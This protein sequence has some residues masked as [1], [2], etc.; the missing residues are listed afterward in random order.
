WLPV[1]GEQRTRAFGAY[2][3]DWRN[4]CS[5][6]QGIWSRAQDLTTTPMPRSDTCGR[7]SE[8]VL[9]RLEVRARVCHAHHA[10]AGDDGGELV[11]APVLGA[12]RTPRNDEIAK[13]G[14][15]VVN[16]HDHVVGKL[17][18]K[19]AQHFARLLHD[20]SPVVLAAVPVRRQAK[21]GAR[22]AGA[23]R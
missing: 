13:V 7:I 1:S 23:E 4:A 18:A 21:H 16:A 14:E 6:A 22:I 9:C 19:F 8:R 2:Q 11:F 5:P 12:G 15:A 3:N 20:A 10:V 17:G